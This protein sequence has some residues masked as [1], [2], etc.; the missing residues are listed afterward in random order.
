M[1]YFSQ[2][3]AGSQLWQHGLMIN[4]M[5]ASNPDHVEHFKKD[6]HE[7]EKQKTAMKGDLSAIIIGYPKTIINPELLDSELLQKLQKPSAITLESPKKE[8]IEQENKKTDI[9]IDEQD[10]LIEEEI[11]HVV[12]KQLDNA[13]PGETVEDTVYSVVQRHEDL[14]NGGV[15]II[16]ETI[17]KI[18]TTHTQFAEPHLD[19]ITT[20]Q[21]ETAKPDETSTMQTETAEPKL[22]EL[23]S[24]HTEVATPQSDGTVT[25][26]T[27]STKIQSEG[28]PTTHAESAD[29]QSDEIATTH[30]D[31]AEPHPEELVTTHKETAEAHLDETATT[32]EAFAEP[33][34]DESATMH[35]EFAEPHSVDVAATHDEFVE[36]HSDETATTNKEHTEQH[37]DKVLTEHS[38][39]AESNK[40]ETA[41]KHSIEFSETSKPE[42]VAETDTVK[43]AHQI[44]KKE[45]DEQEEQ[46]KDIFKEAKEA[47]DNAIEKGAEL[48]K[49]IV[50]E[51]TDEFSKENQKDLKDQKE[52][53]HEHS[54]IDE[55]ETEKFVQEALDETNEI[56]KHDDKY[57]ES[58]NKESEVISGLTD[59]DRP[60]ISGIIT[61]DIKISENND[62][63]NEGYLK[64]EEEIKLKKEELPEEI[65]K[66]EHL[67][68]D[69][70][71]EH[72][73]D[74]REY[75][76]DSIEPQQEKL[77]FEDDGL[78]GKPLTEKTIT[79]EPKFDNLS[80]SKYEVSS[81]ATYS[82]LFGSSG[83][84]QNGSTVVY[85]EQHYEKHL[86]PGNITEEKSR[87]EIYEIPSDDKYTTHKEIIEHVDISDIKPEMQHE[88]TE[89]SH[90]I[91]GFISSALPDSVQ[92]LFSSTRG[93]FDEMFSESDNKGQ[94]HITE[95]TIDDESKYDEIHTTI[96]GD[97]ND[98][99]NQST[100]IGST[101]GNDQDDSGGSHHHY[102]TTIT[103]KTT[104]KKKSK[105][106]DGIFGD[107]KNNDD[108]DFE[109]IH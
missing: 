59:D 102:E 90:G 12:K 108:L 15:D 65:S 80:D 10:H 29:L 69:K 38:D 68:P 5:D 17:E 20:T 107:K 82:T 57:E 88:Q 23:E 45:T 60:I 99:K 30:K 54:K 18:T 24:T 44:E 81:T 74:A 46:S 19:E 91:A 104:T 98:D 9:P 47:F 27:E 85:E 95:R 66:I 72:F 84:E 22:D 83:A 67:S 7:H 3:F 73:T 76:D 34:P 36:P 93:K 4:V 62:K 1:I 41:V 48:V 49:D 43:E 58:M 28:V 70:T 55:K 14:P 39:F 33:H 105:K 8:Q 11:H 79:E 86:E 87:K 101:I 40:D 103:T 75:R 56:V 96:I 31:F 77:T 53:E 32:H 94:Q 42:S 78:S 100:F 63:I 89:K 6:L 13:A 2:Q 97:N 35:K 16:E 52:E 50:A 64:D 37:S 92:N 106:H 51:V 71:D 109:F 26:H 61:E 25:A 21:I